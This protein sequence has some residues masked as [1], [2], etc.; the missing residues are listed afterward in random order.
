MSNVYVDGVFDLFHLGHMRLLIRAKLF[1]TRLIVGVMSEEVCEKYKRRPILTF[2]ER[3][4]TLR[5]S[6]L[7]DFIVEGPFVITKE[8]IDEYNIGCVVHGDDN[9]FP[10]SYAVPIQLEIMKYLPY[11]Q[12]ISTTQIINRIIKNESDSYI[13]G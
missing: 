8:F 13:Y 1:G 2:H 3:V 10:D 9:T 7:A 11:T 5:A 12:E 6:G 4:D